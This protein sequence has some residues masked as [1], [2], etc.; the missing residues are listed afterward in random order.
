MWE[1]VNVFFF[2]AGDL[3]YL[4]VCLP[5]YS[6]CQIKVFQSKEIGGRRFRVPFYK[7]WAASC[8]K[9]ILQKNT[10]L[11]HA[12]SIPFCGGRKILFFFFPYSRTLSQSALLKAAVIATSNRDVGLKS[13]SPITSPWAA[14]TCPGSPFGKARW[15][16][17]A[18]H[19]LSHKAPGDLQRCRC[20]C[21]CVRSVLE[22][23]LSES[24]YWV[25]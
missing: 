3:V 1:I 11:A 19:V 25:H 10:S 21:W 5:S 6:S 9:K 7:Q 18:R 20:V 15:E 17:P 8:Q 12:E 16:H 13:P 23:M 14:P 22:A 2:S 24:W 4:F